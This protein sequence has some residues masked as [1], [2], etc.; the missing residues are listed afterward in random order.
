MK[1]LFLPAKAKK[2]VTKAVAKNLKSIPEKRIGLIS[3]V[4]FIEQLKQVQKI[5][6]AKNKK[7]VIGKPVGPAILK[8][9]ILGCDVSAAT[10]ISHKVDCF[11]YIG[12]GLFHPLGLTTKTNKPIYVLDPFTEN[13]KKITEE[14]KQK[15]FKK[16]ALEVEKL[17]ACKTIGIIMS[18]KPG[19]YCLQASPER[20]ERIKEQFEKNG[21]KVYFFICDNIINTALMDFT[22]IEGWVNTACPRIAEDIFDKPFVN[23]CELLRYF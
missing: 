18:I 19:Q 9:Q 1:I 7:A 8:G 12:T 15:L 4:Q 16:R 10:S 11:L 14:E 5:I 3:T 2:D 23:A 22:K 20:I 6:E 21:K 17:K 13:L